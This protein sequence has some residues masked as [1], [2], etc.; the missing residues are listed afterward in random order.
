MKTK[1][2][3]L[4]PVQRFQCSCPTVSSSFTPSS[5]ALVN[6]PTASHFCSLGVETAVSHIS[7][8]R[9]TKTKHNVCKLEA[10]GLIPSTTPKE[11]PALLSTPWMSVALCHF[12]SSDFT[13]DNQHDAS[14]GTDLEEVGLNLLRQVGLPWTPSNGKLH[15]AINTFISMRIT[16]AATLAK[17]V[18]P[19]R[20]ADREGK[21]GSG[22]YISIKSK[23]GASG[24]MVE[25][26]I[27][28]TSS[29]FSAFLFPVFHS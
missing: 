8:A 20:H 21:P 25:N 28:P 7:I 11:I 12:M 16:A 26:I 24:S 23:S 2:Q 13:E 6:F 14:N 15:S 1:S 5:I 29:S 27:T 18:S 4:R 19:R 22:S 3:H 9:E 17:T 10:M